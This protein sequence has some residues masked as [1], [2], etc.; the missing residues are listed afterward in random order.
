MKINHRNESFWTNMDI[1]IAF[2]FI[3]FF[4]SSP[5]ELERYMQYRHSKVQLHILK[6]IV[7]T[8]HIYN[9]A[10][11][12]FIF[13]FP[14]SIPLDFSPLLQKEHNSLAVSL[15]FCKMSVL[16]VTSQNF[17]QSSNCPSLSQNDF[18][19]GLKHCFSGMRSAMC[20]NTPSNKEPVRPLW[21]DNSLPK[22]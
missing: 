14:H 2:F 21:S 5:S 18:C 8:D 15:H 12:P 7:W 6:A 4:A 11:L 10:H 19:I 20:W 9:Y 13:N 16:L 22:A 17:P 1:L 3:F